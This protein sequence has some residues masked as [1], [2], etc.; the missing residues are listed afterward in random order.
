MLRGQ[1]EDKSDIWSLGVIIYRVLVGS[2][3]FEGDS[4]DKVKQSIVRGIIDF[5]SHKLDNVSV[6]I[7]KFI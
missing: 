1:Y 6:E 4:K 5:D 2:W 7:K 3:P